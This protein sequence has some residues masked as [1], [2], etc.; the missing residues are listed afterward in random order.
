MRHFRLDCL[1]WLGGNGHILV[2]RLLQA[3]HGIDLVWDEARTALCPRLSVLSLVLIA[4]VW[5]VKVVCSVQGRCGLKLC[6]IWE[7]HQP[8]DML[9]PSRGPWR[10][11]WKGWGLPSGTAHAQLQSSTQTPLSWTGGHCGELG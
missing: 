4:E 8:R 1:A 2:G 6:M 9:E 10:L 3:Q 11:G 5:E 7:G